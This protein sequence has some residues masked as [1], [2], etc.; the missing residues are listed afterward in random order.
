MSDPLE[1]EVDNC[2]V[3]SPQLVLCNKSETDFVYRCI[4]ELKFVL[5][6]FSWEIR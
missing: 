2:E 3:Q 6:S 1:L 5:N 4:G